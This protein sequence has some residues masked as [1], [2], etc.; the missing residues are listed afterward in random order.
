MNERPS[1]PTRSDTITVFDAVLGGLT[2]REDTSNWARPWISEREREVDDLAL[3]N[4]LTHLAGVD[5][6]HGAGEPY[7]FTDAQIS[8]WREELLAAP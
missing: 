4:A 8:Q 3:F 6:R 5:L 2:T 1:P 7:L